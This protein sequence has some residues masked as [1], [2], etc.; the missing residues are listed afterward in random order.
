MDPERFPHP[1]IDFV[2]NFF[3][4]SIPLDSMR[5]S[6][7]ILLVGL[8]PYCCIAQ[9]MMPDLTGNLLAG[10]DSSGYVQHFSSSVRDLQKVVLKWNTPD[11]ARIEFFS[12]ERSANGKAFEAVGIIR[13]NSSK[14]LEW[15]DE[16]PERGRNLYR[17]S[18]VSDQGIRLHSQ[19]LTVLITGETSFKFYPNP[20]DNILIIRSDVPIEVTIQDGT[21][22]VRVPTTAIN[23]LHTI[24]VSNLEKG[25]YYLRIRNKLTNLITQEK[26]MKN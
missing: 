16:A 10:T 25:L 22:K 8:L 24:N 19:P 3:P 15:V 26:L 6:L 12:V 11:S 4:F 18:Y 17:I 14:L 21:G 1:G 20:V 5:K 9:M 13:I 23:G 2:N 7:L